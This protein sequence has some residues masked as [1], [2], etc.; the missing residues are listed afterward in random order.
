GACTTD[1]QAVTT[2]EQNVPAA[3]SK[4]QSDQR[5]L[6]AADEALAEAR[7]SAAAYGQTSAYTELPAAGAVV[8]RGQ[9]LYAIDGLPVVLLY[10]STTAWRAFVPGMSSGRDV[11]AL[12]ANLRALGY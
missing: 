10:G 5:A 3:T 8:R 12:N 4:V 2:D 6:A 1:S 7:T 9:S 11:A